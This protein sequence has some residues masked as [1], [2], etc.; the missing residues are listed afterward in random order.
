[1]R[2]PLPEAEQAVWNEYVLDA[3]KVTSQA[4][5]PTGIHGFDADV[6]V[7]AAERAAVRLT[8][9]VYGRQQYGTHAEVVTVPRFPRWIPK[10]LRRRWTKTEIVGIDYRSSVV[11]PDAR[12][13]VP[14]LGRPVRLL[15]TTG[16]WRRP[17]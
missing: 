17:C 3:I 2:P 1:M 8:G 10:W 4:E 7:L 13:P 9:Y 14:E 15:A 16:S 6:A 11:W 12:I 5:I